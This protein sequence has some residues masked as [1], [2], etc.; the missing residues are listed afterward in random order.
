MM[1][2]IKKKTEN[3]VGQKITNVILHSLLLAM[4]VAP[5]AEGHAEPRHEAGIYNWQGHGGAVLFQHQHAAESLGLSALMSDTQVD[6]W[7]AVPGDFESW[8]VVAMHRTQLLFVQAEDGYMAFASL[9]T[10]GQVVTWTPLQADEHH[11]GGAV[12]LEGNSV[13]FQYSPH[14]PLT[15][16]HF[17]EGGQVEAQRV[18]WQDAMGWFAR[19]MDANRILLE[20]AHSGEVTVLA[21]NP[22][23]RNHRPYPAFTLAS[24]WSVRDFAGD[25]VLLYNSENAEAGLLQLGDQYQPTRET[26]LLGAEN[27]WMAI[28]LSRGIE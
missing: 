22:T 1:K 28:A 13:L 6:R 23:G 19:G 20:H 12:A 14:G 15:V 5:V 11:G 8:Q 18:L 21:L 25:T 9:D 27:G 3:F 4:L 7:T 16:I 2:R 24:G 17:D 10:N 26:D